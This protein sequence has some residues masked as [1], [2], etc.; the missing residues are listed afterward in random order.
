MQLCIFSLAKCHI[1]PLK[2]NVGLVDAWGV[3]VKGLF[4]P[5]GRGLKQVAYKTFFCLTHIILFGCT[6][7]PWP[8]QECHHVHARGSILPNIFTE[9]WKCCVDE[10]VKQQQANLL[11]QLLLSVEKMCHNCFAVFEQL[12][13]M[14]DLCESV[15]TVMQSL[16][17][18]QQSR[19]GCAGIQFVAIEGTSVT[20]TFTMSFKCD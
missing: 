2:I 4:V 1:F 6:I 8:C 3:W 11:A 10:L 9:D 7:P 16:T 17:F 18:H 12:I 5:C 19:E 14:T 13:E 15:V 20:A